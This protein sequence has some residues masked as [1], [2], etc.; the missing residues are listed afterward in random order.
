MCEE[1]T[2]A[3]CRPKSCVALR[4][5]FEYLWVPLS[6]VQV[7]VHTRIYLAWNTKPLSISLSAVGS[8]R[9]TSI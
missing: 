8:P 1:R 2:G 6:D 4:D 9:Q 3:A 5:L 7:P